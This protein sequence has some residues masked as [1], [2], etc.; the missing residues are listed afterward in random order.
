MAAGGALG[1][2]VNVNSVE[3]V[4]GPSF[5][6]L[7]AGCEAAICDPADYQNTQ[8]LAQQLCGSF[9]GQNATLASAVSEAIASA[10]A[11]AKE[12]TDGKDVTQLSAL[13]PCGVSIKF[14]CVI[15]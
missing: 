11:I 6:S 4:C 2:P 15:L 9:Y 3:E 10:T 8:L 7:T 5:R 13:P 14:C 12:A 1:S